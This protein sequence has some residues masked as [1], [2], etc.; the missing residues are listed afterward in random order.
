M[1]AVADAAGD[2]PDGNTCD[3]PESHPLVIIPDDVDWDKV[4]AEMGIEPK[5]PRGRPKKVPE[6][7]PKEDG[8]PGRGRGRPKKLPEK[9]SEEYK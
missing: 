1:F 6:N 3:V 4:Y 5:R 9:D 8:V 7:E 2:I